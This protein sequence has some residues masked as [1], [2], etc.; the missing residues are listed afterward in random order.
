MGVA[1]LALDLV[2]APADKRRGDDARMKAIVDQ[3]TAS[4]SKRGMGEP[5]L[6]IVV[7]FH[8]RPRHQ[9][10]AASENWL[11]P[12]STRFGRRRALPRRRSRA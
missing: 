11:C 10:T 3:A 12:A 8:A 6:L 4:L 1:H 7:R 5:E 9:A 2:Y